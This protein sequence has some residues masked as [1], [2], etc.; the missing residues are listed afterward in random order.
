M[1]QAGRTRAQRNAAKQR[2]RE[3]PGKG[4][5]EGRVTGTKRKPCSHDAL[6][7]FR[8]F[9]RIYSFIC[10]RCLLVLWL[11]TLFIVCFIQKELPSKESKEGD[12]EAG[13]ASSGVGPA[14]VGVGELAEGEGVPFFSF[15][16][17]YHY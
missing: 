8:F 10:F 5:I 12:M 6:L 15:S 3:R 4:R 9:F 14:G 13:T 7:G 17:C 2:E 1:T 11:F 16:F